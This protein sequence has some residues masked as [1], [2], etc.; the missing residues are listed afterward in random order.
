MRWGQSSGWKCICNWPRSKIFS[1]SATTFGA[2]PNAGGQRGRPVAMPGML[3]VL[4]AERCATFR[5]CSGWVSARRM[6]P[7]LGVRPQKLFYG[8]AQGYQIS[9]FESPIVGR[10]VLIQ[11]ED[12]STRAP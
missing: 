2:R 10:A 1:G 11:L 9:Q 5:L 8:P 3:P 4:N 7:A 6:P 12:G